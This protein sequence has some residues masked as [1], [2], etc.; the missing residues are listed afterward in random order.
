MKQHNFEIQGDED[1]EFELDDDDLQ[2][3]LANSIL[4]SQKFE[5]SARSPLILP[6]ATSNDDAVLNDTT[7][8]A[9][10]AH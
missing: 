9:Q 4:L 1:G 10:G 2:I 7:T 6:D 5:E 3:D 8:K